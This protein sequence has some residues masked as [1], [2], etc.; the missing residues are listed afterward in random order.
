MPFES[1]LATLVQLGHEGLR[2]ETK[3]FDRFLRTIS[4]IVENG[5]YAFVVSRNEKYVYGMFLHLQ[6][7]RKLYD[8]FVKPLSRFSRRSSVQ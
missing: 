6:A 2:V 1:H 7:A 4:K 5:L 8:R 3:Q